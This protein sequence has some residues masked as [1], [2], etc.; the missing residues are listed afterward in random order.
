MNEVPRVVRNDWSSI[1]VPELGAWK[2][3]LTVSVVIPAYQ[4][5]E[6]LDLTLASL[7][8]QTYPA[9]L[10]EVVVVDDGSEPRLQLPMIRPANCRI[11][12]APEH[13]TGWGIA[14]AV[15]IGVEQSSGEIIQRLDADMVVFPEHIEAHARWHHQLPYAVTLGSK[16]FVD[17][18]P[19]SPTWPTP[20]AVGTTPADQLFSVAESEPHDYIEKLINDTDQL[21]SADHLAFMAHVGATVA[22]RRVMYQRAD[23]MNARL[24]R[25]SDTEFGYRLAQAGAVFIPDHRARSWHLGRSN[26]MRN[27]TDVHRYSRPFLAD[28]MPHPRW[29]RNLGGSGWRVP[30]VK[31]LA[32]VE[33]Q[34]FEVVRAAVDSILHGD[35]RD[36]RVILV[37]SWDKLPD[38]PR[39]PLEDPRLDLRLIAA[40]FGSDPR[41]QLATDMPESAWPAPYSLRMRATVGMATTA[42]RRLI[43]EADRYQAGLVRVDSSQGAPL[44]ELWRS[45]ALGRA[46]WLRPHTKPLT[47]MVAE[48]HGMR[49]MTMSDVGVVDLSG[50]SARQLSAGTVIA[51]AGART[52]RWIPATIQ[53]GGVRSLARAALLVARLTMARA[54]LKTRKRLPHRRAK[55]VNRDVD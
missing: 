47:E 7:S 1:K 30:L 9:E 39:S 41:V 25:G 33:E 53:V 6:S 13:G 17:V 23:G 19:G 44:L 37:G 49:T 40:T 54:R 12:W 51:L 32:D 48:I 2:P 28:L 20:E 45:A 16:R 34:P 42:I 15:N 27:A 3:T 35:E 38:E 14:N 10:M 22:M 26:V 46:S 11:I 36:V 4:C 21:R 55:A 50:V 31:V 43:D 5:Q 52:G 8:R 18:A 24:R 29:L